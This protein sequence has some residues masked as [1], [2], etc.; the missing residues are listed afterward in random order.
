MK[1]VMKD[2]KNAKIFLAH[3]SEKII[4]MSIL[5]KAIQGFIVTCVQIPITFFTKSE[6]AILKHI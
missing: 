3:G 2:T 1:E 6:K 5:R 4:K